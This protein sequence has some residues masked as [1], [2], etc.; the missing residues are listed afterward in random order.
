MKL[1]FDINGG[2]NR[3]EIIKG[4]LDASNEFNTDIILVGEKNYAEE[5]LSRLDY[6]ENKIQIIDAPLSEFMIHWV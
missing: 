4:A 1:I 5:I 3:E 6:N 2:D